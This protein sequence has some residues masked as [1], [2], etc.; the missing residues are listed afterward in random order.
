MLPPNH[1]PVLAHPVPQ[2]MRSRRHTVRPDSPEPEIKTISVNDAMKI[3]GVSAGTIYALC[4]SGRLAHYRIGTGR[5]GSLRFRREDLEEYLE[6]CYRPV[7]R[8]PD[9]EEPTPRRRKVR[10]LRGIKI[11]TDCVPASR[12]L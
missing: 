5:R 2:A 12:R 11:L 7:G 3:L 8:A 4:R 1:L 10:S 6:G 9:A